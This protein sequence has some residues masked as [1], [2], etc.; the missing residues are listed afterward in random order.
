M[1][2]PTSPSAFARVQA[3]VRKIPRGRVATYGQLSAMVERALS[4][5]GIGWALRAAE[6]GTVPWQRVVNARGEISTDGATP[7]LQRAMLEAEGVEFDAAGRIDLARF[8]WRPRA[9]RGRPQAR[10]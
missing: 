5:V 9:P 4:P 1:A 10:R 7:G 3:L 8:G 6:E 2:P